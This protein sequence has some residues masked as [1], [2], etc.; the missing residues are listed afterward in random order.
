MKTIR[1][2]ILAFSCSVLVTFAVTVE[3]AHYSNDNTA[4]NLSETGITP[5]NINTLAKQWAYTLDGSMYAQPL[6]FPIQSG[7][8]TCLLTA[9][10]HNTIS[11]FNANSE[12][13]AIWSTN[14]G[15]S[16]P[17]SSIP[18]QDLIHGTEVGIASTPVVDSANNLGWVVYTTNTPTWKIAKINLATGA[19]ISSAVLTAQVVGTGDA[20]QGDTTSGANLVFYPQYQLQR[21]ALKL[22]SGGK[23]IVIFGSYSDR[24]PWHGWIM[25]VDSTSLAVDHAYCTSPNNYGAG[26]WGAG[27]GPTIDGSGNIY[28]ATGNGTYNGTT[29]WGESILKFDSTLTLTDW[30]TPS[31]WATLFADDSDLSSNHPMLDPN[32]N[33]LFMGAKDFRV[34]NVLRTDMGHLQGGGGTAPQLF[35][36]NASGVISLHS[37]IY[38]GTFCN[39]SL[40]SPNDNGKIY[41][42][43]ISSGTFNTTPTTTTNSYEYSGAI[44]SCSANGASDTLIWAITTNVSALNSYQRGTLRVFSAALVEL[45][46]SDGAAANQLSLISKFSIPMVADGK[47]FVATQSN[48][49]VVYALSANPPA[50]DCPRIL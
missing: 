17:T 11:C 2:V 31:N 43:T 4:A 46:N 15:T 40:Y 19:V 25:S 44:M 34:Y 36:T 41:R 48:Q 27:R 28:V 13:A 38:G 21:G 20:G 42:N 22:T 7:L 3:T 32:S 39:G 33:A 45:W 12:G 24:R 50:C 6:Y 30:F 29:A 47:V 37:G 18:A 16:Y 8:Y 1:A 26:L 14:L 9:T 10:M 49:V 35:F 23:I 5:A